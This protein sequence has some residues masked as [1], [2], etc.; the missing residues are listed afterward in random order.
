MNNSRLSKEV[1]AGKKNIEGLI[2]DLISE[3]EE[4]EKTIDE[5][6]DENDNL[7]EQLSN[8]N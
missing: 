2:D 1:D 3:I 7:R 5:L 8:S 4:L 6:Q